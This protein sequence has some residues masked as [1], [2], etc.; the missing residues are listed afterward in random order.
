MKKLY[1]DFNILTAGDKTYMNWARWNQSFGRRPSWLCSTSERERLSHKTAP[2]THR[3][4]RE[5]GS[6]SAILHSRNTPQI[7]Q[8]RTSYYI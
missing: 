1:Y 2:R 5:F 4:S 6:P 8:P 7:R 3:R